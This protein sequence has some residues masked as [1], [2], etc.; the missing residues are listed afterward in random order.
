M[1]HIYYLLTL[2][3]FFSVN[4]FS[5]EWR[6]AATQ[7]TPI[8]SDAHFLTASVGYYVGASGSV[9]KTTDG[10]VSWNLLAPAGTVSLSVVYFVNEQLGFVGDGATLIHK[11]TD[12]G[13]SW[14]AIPVTGGVG[15]VYGIH[16]LNE[17]TGWVLTSSSSAGKLMYTTDGGVNWSMLLDNPTGDLEA[18]KIYNGTTGIVCGGGVGKMDIYYTANGTTWTKAPPPTLPAGV[19]YTRSDFRAI[20]IQDANLVYLVGWGSL[21]GLQPSMHAKSTDGGATWT[22]LEQQEVN[23][24]FD[25]MWG[26]YFKDANNGIAVGGATRGTVCVR[27]N[28]GGI[29]WVPINIPCGGTLS[30]IDGFGDEIILT[31]SNYIFKST[32][33]GTTW[34]RMNHIPGSSLYAMHSIGENFI[35]AAGFDA[36]FLKS[37]D[38][39]KNW[40]AGAIRAN[41]AA[42]NAQDVFF[43]NENVGYASHGYGMISKTTNGGNSWIQVMKDTIAVGWT[44]YG[45]HFLD[46]NYGFVVAK[47]A[48]NIDGIFKT[49]DGGTTWL[50]KE[51]VF[52]ANLRGVAFAD[53]N[54]G[55][56][57]GEKY[58]IGYTTDG[59]VNWTAATLPSITGAPNFRDVSFLNANTAIAVGDA[60]VL[61]SNDAG[62]TWTNTGTTVP[63]TLTG[64]EFKDQL[65]G[66]AVGAKTSPRSIAI[67][68]TTDGG[69]NWTNRVDYSVFDTMRTVMDVAYTS[70]G[71]AFIC[72]SSSTIYTNALPDGITR[73]PGQPKGFS[74]EQNYPNPFNPETVIRFEIVTADI[75]NLKIYDILGNEVAELVNEFK[76]PGIYSVNF[77]TINGTTKELSTGVY[78][79][80]IKTGHNSLVRKMILIK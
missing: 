28:D 18:L 40:S 70:S 55:V 38:G 41:N 76:H 72:A 30:R 60:M 1:K 75:V 57:V 50:M 2:I 49:T 34:Q 6:V 33:F 12:G 78:F 65:N 66:W 56:V 69:V 61:V 3:L 25:N 54:R 68:L 21:V 19:T 16:F 27:T 73:E 26:V 58:K 32:D 47:T 74:L 4:S 35:V 24:T 14:T 10:G 42:P 77:N 79:Y 29:N 64:L 7:S 63:E 52:A 31:G 45:I 53:Q 36:V 43:V 59:G 8:I 22:F 23:K 46:E 37:V 17:N 71:N 20:H 62:Q 80:K 5:Q 39:G 15:A 67:L 11:T 44:N 51:N 13:L 48:N 9:R